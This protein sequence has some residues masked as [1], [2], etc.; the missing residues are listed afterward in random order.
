MN[1][2]V[3]LKNTPLSINDY[4]SSMYFAWYA[5]FG[6]VPK[7]E[8]IA[9]LYAQYGI[10]TGGSGK[11]CWNF[12][13]GNVKW[14][15]GYDYFMLPGTWE[16]INGKKVVF[17]PPAKETWFRAYSNFNDSMKSHLDFLANRRYKSCWGAVLTGDVAGF[18]KELKK[19][20]YYTADE[21]AYANGM[22]PFYTKFM[23]SGAY[24]LAKAAFDKANLHTPETAPD[25]AAPEEVA[26]VHTIEEAPKHELSVTTDSQPLQLNWLAQI[27]NLLMMIMSLFTKNKK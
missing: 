5:L 23:K 15:N 16:I 20:G 1:Q 11:A 18:A 19:F 4:A 3:P 25:G 24:E 10:E 17:Q 21:T 8:S 26:I 27:Y 13:I 9:V 14:S 2:N 7:A 12:N 6:T 22:K